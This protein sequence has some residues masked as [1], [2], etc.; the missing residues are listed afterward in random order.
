VIAAA[1]TLMMIG[2]MYAALAWR[3]AAFVMLAGAITQML[4]HQAVGFIAY[5]RVMCGTWPSVAPLRDDD[6]DDW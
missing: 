2:G 4:L 1:A 3:P 6:D 5:R